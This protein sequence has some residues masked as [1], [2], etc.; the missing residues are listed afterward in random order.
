MSGPAPPTDPPGGVDGA[1]VSGRGQSC[2]FCGSDDV[3]ECFRQPIEVFRRADL[4]PRR[5]ED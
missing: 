2:A 5:R 3:A 4:G 1:P